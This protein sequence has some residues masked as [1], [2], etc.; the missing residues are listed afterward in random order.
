MMMVPLSLNRGFEPRLLAPRDGWCWR[1]LGP[2]VQVQD[3]QMMTEP[4]PRREMMVLLERDGL[5]MPGV[6]VP[7]Q[8]GPVY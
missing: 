6:Q 1:E 3:G 7:G 5:T 2:K 8:N 4:E